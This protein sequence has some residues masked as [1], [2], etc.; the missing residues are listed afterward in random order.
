MTQPAISVEGLSK[1]YVIGS[2]HERHTT[3]RDA[4]VAKARTVAARVRHP[5]AVS[6]ENQTMWA[7]EDVSFEV[8]S[9]E[10]LGVIG[11]N[12][13]GK[14][15]LLKI[16]SRITE[17]TRGRA[18]VR[19]RIGSLLEVGT[20]FHQE[21]TGRE[22]IMMNGAILGMTRAEI[23]A[24]FDEIVEF[25]EI[26]KFLDTPV[27]RYSSGMYVR[28]AFAVAA[29]M[30]PEILVVDEVL[31]VGD[32][33]FQNKCLGAMGD[34]SRGGRTILFVSHNMAAVKSL[35]SRAMLLE[36]GAMAGQGSTDEIVKL[37]LSA[38]GS[39]ATMREWA[40]ED[41][42][43][44]PYCRLLKFELLEDGTPSSGTVATGGGLQVALTVLVEVPS[45]ILQVG[46]ELASGDAAT[47]LQSYHSDGSAGTVLE[48]GVH[49]AVCTI[50]A[51]LLNSGVYLLRPRVALY[52]NHWIVNGHPDA[53]LRF[54]A[55]LD[56]PQSQLWHVAREG[57]VAPVLDWEVDPYDIEPS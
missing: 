36:S 34:L 52:F 28:L 30:D 57:L 12:G 17:P 9:G 41:A 37:Y 55:Q 38:A 56:H 23:T 43:G 4:V 26:G 16:L 50:P 46:F 35:C 1:S 21:L 13:A 5:G 45:S 25:S 3:L 31:A 32:V 7:L 27:K 47:I 33:A 53:D 11:R 48:R 51:G 2:A 15:T 29:H 10:V 42:L 44:D 24:K 20:G 40:P 54:Q 18:V 19:G 14:T 22:N 6:G 8:Q 49:R 39:G